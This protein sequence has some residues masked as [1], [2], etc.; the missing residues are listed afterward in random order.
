MPHADYKLLD[1]NKGMFDVRNFYN[2]T[3]DISAQLQ[4]CKGDAWNSDS[5]IAF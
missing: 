1:Q 4:G 5:R 3:I 2:N